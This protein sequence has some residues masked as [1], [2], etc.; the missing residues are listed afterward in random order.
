MKKL[1][2]AGLM[3]A[4][5]NVFSQS[6]LILNNGV[7]LTTDNAGFVY[8]FGH[9][10]LPYK[11][12]IVGGQFF[13]EDNKLSTLDLSGFLYEKGKKIEKVKAKGS[14]FLITNDNTLVTIDSKGFFYEFD[15]DDKIFKKVSLFGGNFF[16]VKPDDKKPAVDLYTVNNKGNYFK[17]TVEGLNPAD[18]STV[19]GTYFQTKAGVVYTVSKDGFVFSK[20]SQ[21]VGSISKIGGNFFIDSTGLLFTVSEDGFLMLP[22]LPANIKVS[23]VS[24]L[25]ANFMLDSAGKIFLVDKT[26]A[27]A[28]RTINHD[29]LQTKILGK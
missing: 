9:F 7:T 17:V 13:V 14:N 6:Y 4:S 12:N 16:L 5:I 3:L 22:I 28:E 20:A 18:I 8:D 23:D 2:V 24:K 29:L 11:I 10:H 1:L 21:K 25:G 15:K 19:G 26:G 27:M